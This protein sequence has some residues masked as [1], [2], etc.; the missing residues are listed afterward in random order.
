MKRTKKAIAS[1][2]IAGMAL[3]MI[4]FNALA[5]GAFPTRLAGVKA[6]QTAVAIADQ[7]GWTGTAILASSTSYGMVD[8]LTA[9]PLST[10]LKAPILLTEAGNT[11]NADTKAELTKLNVKT[12]YVTSG[13]AVISQ[14]VINELKGMNITVESL[15]GI[16]RFETSVNIAKKMVTLGAKVSKAAV[17]YGWQY[18]DALSI[19]SIASAQTESILLTDKDTIPPSVKAFLTENKSINTT[20]VIGGTAVISDAVKDQLPSATRY[21]GN[22]AYDTN[23]AVLKAFDSV[24]KYDHVFIAN[25]KTAVD[26]MTGAPLAAKYNASIVLTNGALNEGTN[27]VLN[28]QSSSSIATALGGTAVIPDSVLK[29]TT[30]TTQLDR[31]MNNFVSIFNVYGMINNRFSFNFDNGSGTLAINSSKMKTDPVSS[32]YT[33]IVDQMRDGSISWTEMNIINTKMQEIT[34]N[35]V[36]FNTYIANKLNGKPHSAT[37]IAYFKSPSP[38]TYKALVAAL[39]NNDEYSELINVLN[40]MSLIQGGKVIPQ[41]TIQGQTLLKILVDEDSDHSSKIGEIITGNSYTIEEVKAQF[42]I[43]VTN[44]GDLKFSDLSSKYI[45]LQFSNQTYWF[46]VK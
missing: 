37:A 29:G 40:D 38:E 42:G 19:S 11:L 23:V 6:E 33:T 14:E 17:A 31:W 25:G 44:T 24:L 13:T 46:L 21:F 35:N 12:V 5:E 26:A 36:P 10:V 7:T 34:F 27:Y 4:P 28:K 8:S 45:G 9:G 43:N 30:T 20:D 15:G 41:P 22:T 1:L 18:Q 39:A 32:L 16:D 3:T 2:A